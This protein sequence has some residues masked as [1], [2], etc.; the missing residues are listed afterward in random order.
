MVNFFRELGIHPI[1]HDDF[2]YSNYHTF[3]CLHF[4]ATILCTFLIWSS[5]SDFV[6]P[7]D[8]IPKTAPATTAPRR[9]AVSTAPKVGAAFVES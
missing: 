1:S 2:A 9:R 6:L 3:E 5:K 7:N 4:I 8:Y